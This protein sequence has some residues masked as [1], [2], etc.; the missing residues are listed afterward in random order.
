M[1][2]YQNDLNQRCLAIEDDPS[3]YVFDLI[4]TDSRSAA[5]SFDLLKTVRPEAVM[6]ILIIE[7]ITTMAPSS[8]TPAATSDP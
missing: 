7:V 3:R 6:E 5:P 1:D 4:G 2:K 8:S